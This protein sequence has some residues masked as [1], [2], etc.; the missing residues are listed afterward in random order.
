MDLDMAGHMAGHMPRMTYLL[1]NL[2]SGT[3][4]GELTCLE[5]KMAQKISMQGWREGDL[6]IGPPFFSRL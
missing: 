4:G 3:T 2:F 1:G 6:T 5:S